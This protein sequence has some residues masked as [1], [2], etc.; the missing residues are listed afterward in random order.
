MDRFSVTQ[1]IQP[2]TSGP[3]TRTHSIGGTPGRRAATDLRAEGLE[4]ST[5]TVDVSSV[6][7][8][9]RSRVSAAPTALKRRSQGHR[10]TTTVGI[11]LD[12]LYALVITS[13]QTASIWDALRPFLIT[14]T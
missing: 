9:S 10:R 11:T 3:V 7:S 4:V 8:R 2:K 14:S 5:S 1:A 13:T 6:K 12:Q